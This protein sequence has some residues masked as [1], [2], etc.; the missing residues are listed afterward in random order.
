[1]ASIQTP[2]QSK[3]NRVFIDSSVLIAAAISSTGFARELI[4]QG[5]T[6]K[7]DL[8]ISPD[9]IE[10]AQRNLERKAPQGLEYFYKIYKSLSYTVVKPTK[11]QILKAAKVVVG[12]DAPIVAGAI[13]SKANYL[14]T[15]DRKHLLRHKQEIKDNFKLKVVTPDEL[16]K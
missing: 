1:M 12:K 16:L 9:V 3:K 7:I 13:S 11:K 6:Q 15:F 10:E 2:K 5:F 14:V 8:Y 4:S